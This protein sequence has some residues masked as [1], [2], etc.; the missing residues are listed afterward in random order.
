MRL[1]RQRKTPIP[2]H[3]FLFLRESDRDDPGDRVAKPP[4]CDHGKPG[5]A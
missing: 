4:G 5:T 3:V 1:V 2:S